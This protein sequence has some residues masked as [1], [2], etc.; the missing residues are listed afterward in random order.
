M[1][2]F[3]RL[4]FAFRHRT[5]RRRVASEKALLVYHRGAVVRLPLRCPHQGAPLLH[6][7]ID[8]DCIVCPW[9]GC[10]ISLVGDAPA[11]TKG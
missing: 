10:R 5:L 8:G 9:H 4:A 11:P 2:L 3:A 1:A 7:R 6:G